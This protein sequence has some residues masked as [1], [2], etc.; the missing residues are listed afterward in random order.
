MK[1]VK[2]LSRQAQLVC[3]V[4]VDSA[5]TSGFPMGTADFTA[6]LFDLVVSSDPLEQC[7]LCIFHFP[8]FIN[9]S[10]LPPFSQTV[11]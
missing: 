9:T 1:K 8:F 4:L 10:F 7:S 5:V 2:C 3:L 11:R 6:A